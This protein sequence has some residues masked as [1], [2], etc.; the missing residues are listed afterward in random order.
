MSAEAE[1]WLRKRVRVGAGCAPEVTLAEGVVL[2]YS[3]APTIMVRD[4][5]GRDSHWMVT[6]PID[7]LGEV[8]D[9]E[10]PERAEPVDTEARG[11]ELRSQLY[12]FLG[13][14]T[15]RAYGE[16]HGHESLRMLAD[17]LATRVEQLPGEDALDALLRTAGIEHPLGLRGVEDL[18]QQRDG[19]LDAAREADQLRGLALEQMAIDQREHGRSLDAV[20]RRLEQAEAVLADIREVMA[21][22]LASSEDDDRYTLNKIHA[23]LSGG[24]P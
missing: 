10:L 11:R 24:K 18:I 1:R 7:V 5:Q 8:P 20:Q 17:E 6:L 23:L 16:P 12:E 4:E 2:A 21:A 19:Y 14:R 13:A 22:W 9:D 15:S 3:G